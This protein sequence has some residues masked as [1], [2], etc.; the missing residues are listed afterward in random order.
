[1]LPG[2]KK[3][4][5]MGYKVA[6]CPAGV[7]F[8]GQC[9]CVTWKRPSWEWTLCAR[10]AARGQG[11]SSPC[12][13]GSG[14]RAT[15]HMTLLSQLPPPGASQMLAWGSTCEELPEGSAYFP[16]MCTLGMPFNWTLPW[17][18]F[19]PSFLPLQFSCLEN[20]M[21]G[22]ACRLQAMGSQ[23][24]RHDWATSLLHA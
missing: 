21:E 11:F 23:R 17:M 16:R 22:G 6:A 2:G 12:P 8:S 4:N 14:P 13:L 20:P 7:P 18:H 3:E 10:P 24:V 1:M 19:F 15:N 5:S 9:L